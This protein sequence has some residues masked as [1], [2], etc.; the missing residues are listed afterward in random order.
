MKSAL[1]I[2]IAILGAAI[3]VSAFDEKEAMVKF[4]E[5]AEACVGEVGAKDSDLQEIVKKQPASTYEGKCL[6]ACVMKKVGVLGA[7]GKLDVEAGHAKA[8][9]YTG[10]DPS[11][12]KIAMEI[13]E[14]C[15]AISVSDDHCEAAETYGHCFKTEAEKHGLM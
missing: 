13:G 5:F 4:M 2:A 6:R 1:V 12:I 15:A 14:T 3:L 9:Q 10:N 11:K 7:N 8:K